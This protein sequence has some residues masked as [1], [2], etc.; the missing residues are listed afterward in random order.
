MG[1]LENMADLKLLE[2]RLEEEYG[3]DAELIASGN[4]IRVLRKLWPSQAPSAP[5]G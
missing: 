4:A 5:N 2:E 3:G 1:G